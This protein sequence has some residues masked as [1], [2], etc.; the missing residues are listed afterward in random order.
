MPY[1]KTFDSF[2]P[3]NLNLNQTTAKSRQIRAR[4]HTVSREIEKSSEKIKKSAIEKTREIKIPKKLLDFLFII[5][6]FK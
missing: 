4:E 6:Y 1:F 2:P 5:Q 3:G